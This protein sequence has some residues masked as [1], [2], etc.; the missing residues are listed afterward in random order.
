LVDIPA[1]LL[2]AGPVLATALARI[3]L[4]VACE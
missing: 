4:N 1:G 2:E 3:D